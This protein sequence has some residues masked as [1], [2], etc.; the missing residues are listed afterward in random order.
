MKKARTGLLRL[1]SISLLFALLTS[2]TCES[3]ANTQSR[4]SASASAEPPK[5]I[6]TV[7][8]AKDMYDAYSKHRVPII[9]AYED[10]VRR[11]EAKFDVARYVYYDYETIKQY[12]AYIEQEAAAADVK[13]SKLRFYFSNYPDKEKFPD[14]R[15]ILHPKQNSIMISPTL[16]KGDRDYLFYTT[17]G[18]QGKRKAVLLDDRFDPEKEQGMG[19]ATRPTQRN[20]ASFIPNT[21]NAASTVRPMFVDKSMTLNEGN[22]VPPPH[23]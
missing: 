8:H 10:S 22:S 21:T 9:E 17:D 23:P 7:E 1:L 12:L 11:N 14:G 20:E 4:A 5:Q 6:V 13:I 16:D 3:D 2:A 18:E 19:A 15:T